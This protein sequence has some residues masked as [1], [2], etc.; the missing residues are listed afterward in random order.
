MV[1]V[2]Y[3]NTSANIKKE[4]GIILKEKNSVIKKKG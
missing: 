1:V 3:K 4:N 2:Y